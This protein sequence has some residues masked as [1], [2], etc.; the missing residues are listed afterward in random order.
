MP[1]W[2]QQPAQKKIIWTCEFWDI[3][4]KH[5]VDSL[6]HSCICSQAPL[7]VNCMHHHLLTKVFGTWL[8]N[9]CEWNAEQIWTL[10]ISNCQR[11][12]SWGHHWRIWGCRW[13]PNSQWNQIEFYLHR[14]AYCNIGSVN[15]VKFY[16]AWNAWYNLFFLAMQLFFNAT[17]KEFA[18]FRVSQNWTIECSH[19][20]VASNIPKCKEY[21]TLKR[22]RNEN[23]KPMDNAKLPKHRTLISCPVLMPKMQ[24]KYNL[25]R[26][27]A[28][29]FWQTRLYNMWKHVCRVQK[30]E[31]RILPLFLC[32]MYIILDFVVLKVKV[33]QGTSYLFFCKKKMDRFGIHFFVACNQFFGETRQLFNMCKKIVPLA[34]VHNFGKPNWPKKQKEKTFGIV[35]FSRVWLVLDF[36]VFAI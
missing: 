10:E 18:S 8:A 25:V 1:I 28:T 21:S 22:S 29:Q 19:V 3:Q 32:I 31:L 35:G 11:I 30:R 26:S 20:V 36:H 5:I 27:S 24:P 33:I 6:A 14:Q 16:K 7:P 17:T 2:S 13:N 9:S 34:L 15:A 4:W 23:K 12:L